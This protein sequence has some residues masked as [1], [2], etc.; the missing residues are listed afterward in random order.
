MKSSFRSHV[1]REGNM[2]VSCACFKRCK[3]RPGLWRD[4]GALRVRPRKS[5]HRLE[6]F[7]KRQDQ[8]FIGACLRPAQHI[9]AAKARD[10]A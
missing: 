5:L 1:V 4:D 6:R 2:E 7:P 10:C 3:Q 8:E 9:D